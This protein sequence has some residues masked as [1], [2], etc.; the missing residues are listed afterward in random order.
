MSLDTPARTTHSDNRS[1]P[2]PPPSMRLFTPGN[3][4]N[5][6]D[7]SDSAY[8]GN[9][10]GMNA[11]GSGNTNGSSQSQSHFEDGFQSFNS[12]AFRQD[13]AVY[14]VTKLASRE[15]LD[16]AR[17]R[18]AH[19]FHMVCPTLTSPFHGYLTVQM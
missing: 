9:P 2:Y 5:H 3:S 19:E 17:R 16:D 4:Q 1:S 13:Q 11:S 7:M 15:K 6:E 18:L 8:G 14:I 10:S 12:Q